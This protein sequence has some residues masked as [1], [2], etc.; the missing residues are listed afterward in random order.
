MSKAIF[1]ALSGAVLKEKQMEIISQNLAN[2][3]SSAYKKMRV[4]FKD[5][6]TSPE[7]EQEGKIMSELS[8]VSTDFSTGSF[9]QTGNPLDIALEGKGF[10]ALE[11]NFFTRRGDFKRNSEGYLTTQSGIPVLGSRGVPIDIP[12]GKLEIGP[13]GEVIVN[14]TP[15]DTLKLVDFANKDSLTRLGEDLFQSNDPGSSAKAVFKQGHLEGSN[16]EVVKEMTQ[17]IMTL[18]EFQAFQK[19]IQGFDDIQT[20]MIDVARI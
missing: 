1:I 10:F 11:G 13:G 7:S 17:I 8:S 14:Q 20:K 9:H 5:Y 3:N 19:I 12:Q 2:S 18:R 16:V 15:V 4:A 6:L